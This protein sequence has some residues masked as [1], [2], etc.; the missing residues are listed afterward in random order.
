MIYANWAIK[1][2]IPAAAMHD[3][4]LQLGLEGLGAIPNDLRGSSEAAAQT[5]VRLEAARID[6]LRLYR[7]NS[8]A[9]KDDTGRWVRY[10]L[11]NDSKQMNE[12]MKSPDLVGWRRTLI[13]P[14]MVG[15]SFARTVLREVK[16]P[17]WQ[18]V[19]DDHEQ[20]QLRFLTLAIADGADAAFCTGAGT[21]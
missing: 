13:T 2:G 5:A 14:A 1:W 20:A 15:T 19:G 3:L 6:G 7:N 8:G 21:L 17:G 18:Y 10:G 9:Y 16:E 11:A 4:A 12:L